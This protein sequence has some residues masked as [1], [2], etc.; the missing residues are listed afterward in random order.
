MIMFKM[1]TWEIILKDNSTISE[2]ETRWIDISELKEVTYFG[3]K[4][5]VYV[6]KFLVKKIKCYLDD[7][8]A[9]I[10]V[11]DN[12]FVYQANR[13]ETIIASNE[14]RKSRILGKLLGIIKN[15]EVVEEKYINLVENKVEGFKL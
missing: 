12:C 3:K 9:E 2:E 5:S 1:K 6:C 15:G 4:K 10:E 14:E 8:E 13:G 7:F 11:P